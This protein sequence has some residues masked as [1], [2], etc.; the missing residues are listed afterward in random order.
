MGDDLEVAVFLRAGDDALHTFVQS[1]A[2]QAL[3]SN[4]VALKSLQSCAFVSDSC[5]QLNVG[6]CFAGCGDGIRLNRAP[7]RSA[8][9][10]WQGSLS[11][12][13]SP[14]VPITI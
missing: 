9:D 13:Y 1:I 8:D 10:S 5:L 11:W 3:A 4:F 7:K 14:G 6:M 2:F 12:S